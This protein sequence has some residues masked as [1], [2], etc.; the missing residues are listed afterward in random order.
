METNN[1]F[2][3]ELPSESSQIA[4]SELENSTDRELDQLELDAIAGGRSDMADRARA[5]GIPVITAS[6]PRPNIFGRGLPMQLIEEA[7]RAFG[8]RN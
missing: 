3:Q 2:S 6:G 4:A 1:R 5:A 7:S 8:N